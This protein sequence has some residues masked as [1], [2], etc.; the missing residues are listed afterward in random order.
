MKDYHLF[1]SRE[2]V[3]DE[4]RCQDVVD[5]LE[6][7][8]FLDILVLEEEGRAFALN[9]ACSVQD[10]EVFEEVADVVGASHRDLGLVSP[11]FYMHLLHT[12]RS[13]KHK[14]YSQAI[15]LICACGICIRKSFA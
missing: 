14:K 12:H 11:T 2:E 9:A 10:F 3:G 5:I 4:A 7:A 1:I 15:S 6:E 13:Q 8:L